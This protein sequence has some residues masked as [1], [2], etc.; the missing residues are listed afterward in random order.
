M[1]PSGGYTFSWTGY[2]GA[3]PL[4]QRISRFRIEQI[5]SDRVE[6]EQAYDMKQVSAEVGVFFTTII[7]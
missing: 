4:G 7:A 6:I 2:T 3:G 1:V 5:R